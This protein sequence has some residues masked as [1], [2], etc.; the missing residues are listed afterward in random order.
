MEQNKSLVV[1]QAQI[2][3]DTSAQNYQKLLQGVLKE[4]KTKWIKFQE[5]QKVKVDLRGA[6]K[7]RQQLPSC[8]LA[9]QSC[10]ET[11]PYAYNYNICSMTQVH[12]G[13][14]CIIIYIL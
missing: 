1:V 2:I 12:T 14:L 11:Q 9:I 8:I 4:F 3:A 10:F 5:G 13:A 7:N 6:D